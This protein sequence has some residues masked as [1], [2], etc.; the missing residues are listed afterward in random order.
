MIK[1]LKKKTVKNA[2]TIENDIKSINSKIQKL[3]DRNNNYIDLVAD[4]IISKKDFL[5]KKEEN[6]NEINKL[7]DKIEKL[8][9]QKEDKSTPTIN[10]TI[11]KDA[12][13]KILDCSNEVNDG[14]LDKFVYRII[15][16]TPDHFIWQLHF[17]SIT[18][19]K[20]TF[21]DLCSYHIDL[22]YAKAYSKKH[23]TIIHKSRW[24]DIDIDVQIAI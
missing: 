9:S 11:L 12:L 6:E 20:P 14:I 5:A 7:Q 18:D 21:I 17:K 24:T 3:I 19:N 8:Q 2:T 4:G 16:D 22:E 13:S 10:D 23:K 1:A 15:V